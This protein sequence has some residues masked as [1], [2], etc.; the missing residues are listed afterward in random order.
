MKAPMNIG[1]AGSRGLTLLE[2]MVSV[3][4]LAVI[5]IGLLAM[6]NQTQK[7]LRIVNAQSDVFENSRAAVQMMTRDLM[8]MTASGQ[9]NVV[10][11]FATNVLS[12]V[13]G[14]NLPVPGP[15]PVNVPVFFGE[16]FWLTRIN[17]EWRG[18]GYFVGEAEDARGSKGVGTLYRYYSDAVD[19]FG[20]QPLSADFLSTSTNIYRVS[21][22][23]VHFLMRA[24]YPELNTNVNP[25][26]V[27]YRRSQRFAFRTNDLPAYVDIEF[28]ILEPE[29]LKQYQALTNL[30]DEVVAQNFLRDH[31][32]NIH[33]FRERVPI[34]N[35]INPYRSN[36]LP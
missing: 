26:R 6:F 23:V 28:G 3:T 21:D 14:G 17:D 2:I 29:T 30:T 18:V 32:G 11:V 24:V 12:P 34:R 5:M 8:E 33:F 35:F 20:L 36:E 7:A 31:S 1:A 9:S 25:S 22:G 4:L 10:N 13:P 19:R 27:E 15:P 16:A